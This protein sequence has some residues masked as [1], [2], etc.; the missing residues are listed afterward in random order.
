MKTIKLHGYHLNENTILENRINILESMISHL[1]LRLDE[2]LDD[3]S[4]TSGELRKALNVEIGHLEDRVIMVIGE[5]KKL[6]TKRNQL[7]TKQNE[8]N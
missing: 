1:N 3:L 5:Q 8:N 6:W 7:N 4:T 2:D